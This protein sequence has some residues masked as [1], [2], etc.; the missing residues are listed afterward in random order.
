MT[1]PRRALPLLA[2]VLGGASSG[3]DPAL[4]AAGWQMVAVP[5]RTPARFVARS[6]G[7]IGMVADS[8]V[9]FL[10]RRLDGAARSIAWRWRVLAA[11]PATDLAT[12]DA[13]DRPAAVHLLFPA[14]GGGLF[15][16]LRRGLRSAALGEAFAGRALTYVWGGRDPPGTV[17]HNPHLEDDGRLVVRRG[18]EAPLGVWFEE[19][20]EVA[21]DWQKA[22]GGGAP[23]PTH[24]ALSIDTDDRGGHAEA[25]IV[26]PQGGR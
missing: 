18:P 1:V 24:V 26:P 6:D 5:R 16:S 17:L 11:P 22:F 23:V 15:T 12:K 13:D 8:A 10:V 25:E 21:A 2:G 3:L 20:V 7:A 14:G 4:A 9:G 19:R